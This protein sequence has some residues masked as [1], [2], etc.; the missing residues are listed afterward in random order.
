[1]QKSMLLYENLARV[2]SGW[3]YANYGSALRR[4]NEIKK[5]TEPGTRKLQQTTKR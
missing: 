1:M 5:Y 2:I 3:N 4:K